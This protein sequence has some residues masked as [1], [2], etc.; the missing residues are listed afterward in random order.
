MA[1]DGHIRVVAKKRHKTEILNNFKSNMAI[2]GH[3]R[4][5]A[6]KITMRQLF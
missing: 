1:I 6:K 3:I 2:D 5:V 4:V